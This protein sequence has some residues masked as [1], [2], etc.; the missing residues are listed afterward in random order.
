MFP[1]CQR[2]TGTLYWAASVP[3]AFVTRCFKTIPYTHADSAPLQVLS[4]LIK[5]GYLHREIREKGG[6]YGGLASYDNEAGIFSFLSYRDPHIKRTLQVYDDAVH[7]AV[8][9]EFSDEAINEAL[10]SVFSNLDRPLSPGSRGN[11][12]FS[13]LRQGLTLEMRQQYRRNLLA[14]TR[15]DLQR[16]AKKYMLENPTDPVDSILASED[17]LK[18]ELDE[19]VITINRV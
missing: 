5:D 17:K 11:H 10:L 7:W 19:T 3:V 2:G 16:V 13:N 15:D 12:E 8:A 4:K 6:A 14:T 18:S 9:G 1:D